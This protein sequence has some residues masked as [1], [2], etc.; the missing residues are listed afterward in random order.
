MKNTIQI[1]AVCFFIFAGMAITNTVNAQTTG[2]NTIQEV[3]LY[4]NDGFNEVREILMDNFDFTASDYKQGTVN[5]V[6]KFEV[7]ENGKIVNVHSQGECRN[8]SREIENVLKGSYYNGT[9]KKSAASADMMAYTYVMPVT[10]EID[11]R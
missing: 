3:K 7:A 5:S 6:V 1:I 9:R 2:S 4:K 10:L 11:Q 8:V